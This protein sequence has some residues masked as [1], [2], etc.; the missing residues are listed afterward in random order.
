MIELD[1][2]KD[3]VILIHKELDE[4][5][6]NTITSL[7]KNNP[8]VIISNPDDLIVLRNFIGSGENPINSMEGKYDPN[9]VEEQQT[10]EP[11]NTQSSPSLVRDNTRTTS[12][13]DRVENA[14]K[15]VSQRDKILD[16]VLNRK[17]ASS[18]TILRELKDTLGVRFSYGTLYEFMRDN[19]Y[20]RSWD[21]D[22]GFKRI[23]EPKEEPE[24]EDSEDESEN[25]DDL[26]SEVRNY[27][28]HNSYL[29]ISALQ[30]K[31]SERFGQK[32]SKAKLTQ[33]KSELDPREDPEE[34]GLELDDLE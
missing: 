13:Y 14:S 23:E 28:K 8:I 21:S 3:R 31:I 15:I 4:S 18:S 2:K 27:I 34:E 5:Q 19:G 20:Q 16:M 22:N 10:E 11:T 24:D 6:I 29:P 9:E 1:G 12:D 32:I 33:L 26:D 25:S 7:I 17:K 30:T